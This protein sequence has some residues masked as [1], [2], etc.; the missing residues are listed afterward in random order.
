M[1]LSKLNKTRWGI[2]INYFSVLLTFILFELVEKSSFD[3]AKYGY[4]G[5]ILAWGSLTGFV[6]WLISFYKI[7]WKTKWWKYVHQ[8]IDKLDERERQAVGEAVRKSYGY[9]T[10]L[11]LMTIW[12]FLIFKWNPDFILFWV[13]LYLAHILPASILKWQGY[14]I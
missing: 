6:L 5:L 12:F 2:G 7:Y 9:F 14:K 1:S 3:Q 8:S 4:L 11:I 10:V 13:S